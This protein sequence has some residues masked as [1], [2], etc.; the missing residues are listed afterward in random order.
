MYNIKINPN[1][2]VAAGS[3]VTRNEPDGTIVGGNLA[4]AIGRFDTLMEKRKE[5]L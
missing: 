3:G 2:I 1:A 4:R 5:L